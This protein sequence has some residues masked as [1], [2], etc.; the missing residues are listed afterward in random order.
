MVK[1]HHFG[2]SKSCSVYKIGHQNAFGFVLSKHFSIEIGYYFLFLFY[3][4]VA[5]AI[6]TLYVEYPVLLNWQFN[7]QLELVVEIC[8]YWGKSTLFRSG[9]PSTRAAAGRTAGPDY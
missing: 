4:L 1:K 7:M 9:S 5:A 6:S 3:N 2:F 8:S